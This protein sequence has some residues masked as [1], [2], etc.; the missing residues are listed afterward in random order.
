MGPR[1]MAA[2]CVPKV[3]RSKLSVSV[4]PRATWVRSMV[5]R[6]A[7]AR[8]SLPLGSSPVTLTPG[9]RRSVPSAC[10]FS[11]SSV[12]P[13]P[14][15]P[16]TEAPVVA[17]RSATSKA[18]GGLPLSWKRLA[19]E[20]AEAELRLGRIEREALPQRGELV[21]RLGEGRGARADRDAAGDGPAESGRRRVRLREVAVL[22]RAGGRRRH[23]CGA[24]APVV[25]AG[26][27][28]SA[29]I[30]S[31]RVTTGA[32]GAV[33][34]VARSFADGRMRIPAVSVLVISAPGAT[35]TAMSSSPSAWPYSCS[36]TVSRSKCPAAAEPA[37]AV[38][39]PSGPVANSE[40]P[41]RC[42]SRRRCRW[43]RW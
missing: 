10:R 23:A 40:P 19:A 27:P 3:M 17:S 30:I 42:T 4:R 20:D 5:T 22:Q 2:A 41:A 11:R 24:A 14:I 32:A 43:R 6:C 1:L 13:S 33:A 9:A 38:S 16:R 7:A 12:P 29:S 8:S 25:A 31:A 34:G 15:G 37:R 35:P 26:T 21:A 36:S 39:M 18:S 28:V